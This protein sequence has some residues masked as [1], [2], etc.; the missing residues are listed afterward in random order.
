[1]RPA[2]PPYIGASMKTSLGPFQ[3][4]RQKQECDLIYSSFPPD[5]MLMVSFNKLLISELK[6]NKK[7]FQTASQD[8]A[9]LRILIG[10]V[11]LEGQ[12]SC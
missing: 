8:S 12:E 10:C 11:S 4:A 6:Q 7:Q 3:R 1:M 2:S 9:W 5:K